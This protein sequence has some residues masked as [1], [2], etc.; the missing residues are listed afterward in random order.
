[1]VVGGEDAV[2]GGNCLPDLVTPVDAAELGAC[3]YRVWL[4]DLRGSA[5]NREAIIILLAHWAVETGRGSKCHRFNVGNA[6]ASVGGP[7]DYTFFAC[8]EELSLA[9]A[10]REAAKDPRVVILRKYVYG[11]RSLASCHIMPKHPWSCFRAFDDLLSGAADHLSLIHRRYPDAFLAALA[12]H[13]QGYA[14]ELKRRGYYTASVEQYSAALVGSVPWAKKQ[15]DR[16]DWSSLPGLS[17]WEIER[18]NG[19]V[20]LSAQ[21]TEDDWQAMRRERDEAVGAG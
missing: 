1:M 21:L 15:L 17:S 2:N 14:V 9:T 10:E 12:N 7:Y 13:P 4:E 20:A 6:K 11:G 3:F 8:G 19:V 16:S 18:V 5:P